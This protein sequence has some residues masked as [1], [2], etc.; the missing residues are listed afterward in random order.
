M[1]HTTWI[2]CLILL[3]ISVV[4]HL[5]V[6]NM[7]LNVYD[8]GIILAGADRIL[9]GQV[10]YRDFWSMY[11]PGQ[12]YTLAL[13]FKFFGPSVL[14]E[15]I[16][17]LIVRSLLATSG[18]LVSRRLGFSYGAAIAGW[19][20]ALLWTASTW[21]P[22]YPVYAALLA[23]YVSIAF[24]LHYLETKQAR[25]LF[26]SG[27]A[28]AIGLT[29]RHDLGGMAAAVTLVTLLLLGLTG[30]GGGWRPMATYLSGGLSLGLPVALY[31]AV[32]V[33]I[34]PMWDQLIATPAD[35][36]PRF[37]WIPYPP[38]SFETL[39]FYLFPIVLGVG[40][41]V[42]LILIKNHKRDTPAYGLFVLS[43]T[44]L[45]FLNQV[46][47]RSDEIHLFPAA[48]AS[49]IVLPGLVSLLLSSFPKATKV[50]ALALV[51]TTSAL[52][53]GRASDWTE[54]FA[55]R[56]FVTLER[57]TVARAGFAAIDQNLAGVVVF[58][59]DNTAENEA[60]YVGVKN[61]DQFLI[62]DTI[63]P[64]LADRPYATRYHELHPGVTTTADV[65]KEIIQELENAPAR[66]IVL[67][68]GYWPEP[69][70]TS[71]DAGIDLLDRYIAENYRLVHQ[72][73]DYELWMSRSQ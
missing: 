38:Y 52:F 36:M 53:V 56:R 28:I 22:A 43:L 17:G 49:I 68:P 63:I 40:L 9:Q 54:S 35:V 47:V 10:P 23:I 70:E 11:P 46:R 42:S 32:T 29:F 64:F 50:V 55:G 16:Y 31:F 57:S 51:V 5:P 33:G 72:V 39:A 45:L 13:L 73:G 26:W 71:I 48:I 18:F 1:K 14:V 12:F 2:L 20:M 67:R 25:W 44:G 4:C 34:G 59:Q 24:F 66:L 8:E 60:I 19:V 3:L 62:N 65:Q 30:A 27:L 21:F 61:H 69:N 41:I 7:S 6:L 15:R 58:I 37:R